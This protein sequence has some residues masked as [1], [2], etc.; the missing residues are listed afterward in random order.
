MLNEIAVLFIPPTNAEGGGPVVNSAYR[1]AMRARTVPPQF[2]LNTCT[3]N[4][5][6]IKINLCIYNLNLIAMGQVESKPSFYTR[7][8]NDDGEFVIV[9]DNA[10]VDVLNF[11]PSE[12]YAVGYGIDY[13][14]SPKFKHKTLSSVTVADA[15][16]ILDAVVSCGSI[17]AQHTRLYAASK[18]IEECKIDGIKH[19]FQEH[20]QKV[21]VGGLFHF[22]FSGH[23]IR[24]GGNEWGLAP[25]DFDYTHATYL[26]ANVL[27]EWLQ[28]ANC[29]A[30]LVLFTLDCCY[31][32]GIGRE[33]TRS[34]ALPLNAG[35]YVISACTAN[36]ASLV[37]GPLGHS[38]FTYFLSYAIKKMVRNGGELPITRVFNECQV[39]SESLSSLLVSYKSDIGLKWGTMQPQLGVNN[40]STAVKVI[41]GED[42]DEIDAAAEI[43]RFQ[44]AQELY[45]R[46]KPIDPLD[47]KSLAFLDTHCA[48]VDSALIELEKRHLLKGRVF[49]TALCS[50][51]YSIASIEL[52]CD[53]RANM[54][55]IRNPNLSITAFIHV[56]AT[57]DMV[58]RG[59]TCPE[60][61]FFLSW[62]FY[63]EVLVS[64]GVNV[65]SL[66]SLHRKLSRSKKFSA[67]LMKTPSQVYNEN[68]LS[69]PTSDGGEDL[70]DSSEVEASAEV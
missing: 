1:A 17:P 2:S 69:V 18:E 15:K 5:R 44:Y 35:L 59:I 66:K 33:L 30:K 39:C 50:M 54:T 32:G 36:E 45:D 63:R 70:T 19:S 21:G 53:T 49:Q 48:I 57:I 41:M 56:I 51:M 61:I 67:P 4:K 47:D 34:V 20:A 60:N 11:D 55:K 64:N 38:I 3:K 27:T 46:R 65:D 26:T 58:H 40:I 9:S 13:Q 16:Q 28:E 43:G 68:S 14:T 7:V 42:T 22:H 12:S 52:A 29:R 10:S 24:V 31:A 8:K 23:G 6:K 37:L 25:V 62:L